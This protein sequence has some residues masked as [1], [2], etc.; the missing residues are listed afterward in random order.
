MRLFVLPL[1]ALGVLPQGNRPT[2]RVTTSYSLIGG[3]SVDTAGATRDFS[4]AL[5]S[6]SLV[7]VLPALPRRVTKEAN[8]EAAEF[9]VML[10][11]GGAPSRYRVVVRVIDVKS[12]RERMSESAQTA[13][14]DSIPIIARELARRTAR[15]L[16][17]KAP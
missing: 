2:V 4:A 8:I 5:G 10:S 15:T 9:G 17:G 12:A 13:S 11:I 6:E 14:A 3:A 7:R 16:A 1:I